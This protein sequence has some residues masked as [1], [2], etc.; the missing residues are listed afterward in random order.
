MAYPTVN[1]PYG[2]KP[3][4]LIGGQVFAGQTRELPIA[5]NYGT[6]INNGDIV[7]LASGFIVK[8]TGT[9]TVSATGVVGVFVGVSYTNPSTGQKLFA[10]SYP[11]SVV[12]SDIVAYVVDDPDALFKVAVT[13]GATSTTITPVD[14]TILGNNMAISQ[15][16]TNT[17]IS[18]NSNIGA[19]DSGSNTAA[20][21]PLRV[22]GLIEETVDSSGNYSEV[23][24]KWNAPYMVSTTTS[25]GATPPVFTTTTVVTG[26]H[27]YLNPTGTANV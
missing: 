23:I 25:D 22:V 3:I 21:L 15:P 1:A 8:E 14:N 2:L 12:A 11:G 5:S 26:G 27:S 7:R 10:N 16:S 18:G 19:Y 17:T 20:S 24:V 4:N 9:T 6:V 13:G